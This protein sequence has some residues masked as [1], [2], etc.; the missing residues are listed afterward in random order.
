ML[1]EVARGGLAQLLL[2]KAGIDLHHLAA[3]LRF[4]HLAGDVTAIACVHPICGRAGYETLFER[5]HHESVAGVA[6]PE[7]SIAIEDGDFGIRL[8]D[9]PFELF[10]GP[11]DAFDL[12]R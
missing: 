7:G 9:E 12:L 11:A 5:P 6:A 8:E 1:V 3:D 4:A 2:A 10:S